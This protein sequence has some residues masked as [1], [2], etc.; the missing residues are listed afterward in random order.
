M[1]SR[2]FV[3][4]AILLTLIGAGVAVYFFF[5]RGAPG[6]IVPQE[7]GEFGETPG[8][9]VP[10]GESGGEGEVPLGELDGEAGEEVAPNLVKITDGPV[11]FGAVALNFSEEVVVPVPGEPATS[12]AT[13]TSVMEDAEVRYIE[14]ESGNVYAYRINERTLTRLSNRTLPGV[15]EAS[16]LPD[17]SLA[18]ARFLSEDEGGGEHIETYA[19]SSDMGE[20]GGYF[21][22]PDLSEV[23]VSPASE[24]LTLLPSTSGS[25]GT[26][27]T[28]DGL[29][30]QTLFT[31]PLTSLRIL[32]AGDDWAAFTKA[33]AQVG[34]YGFL[35]DGTS[36]TFNRVLGPLRGLTALPS[37]SGNMMLYSYFSGNA[38]RTELM[39][40]T[41]RTVTPIPLSALVEK[42]VWTSDETS[43][44]CAVPN[45]LSGTLPDDWYQ[46]AVQFT[47][48]IWK[49]DI[50][51]R[52]AILIVDPSTVAEV[53]V[54]AVN[55]TL[56][57]GSD[58]LVFT[59]RRDGSLWAYDL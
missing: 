53:S 12:T 23:V 2:F 29:N 11:A 7:G 22:E 47:D 31:S 30:P 15:Y 1:S 16:W 44:Y 36:G 45:S 38:V 34:G 43:V 24:L 37:P 25:I 32:P 40:M 21:L 39:D 46:G 6:L 17:G 55:L 49:I 3:V 14:R 19:L 26:V 42:C 35:I 54:D 58:A 27:A 51:A 5:F 20:E 50:G 13:T 28:G 4:I 59:N 33:S 41:T 56:D 8:E 9:Y 18:Y 10:P 52:V 57:P 48:R